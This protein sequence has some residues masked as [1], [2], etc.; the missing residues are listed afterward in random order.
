MKEPS[1]APY[2]VNYVQHEHKGWIAVWFSTSHGKFELLRN[3]LPRAFSGAKYSPQY[4]AWYLGPG[5]TLGQLHALCKR[6]DATAVR[7]DMES[8]Q[9]R[10]GD[11]SDEGIATILYG[12]WKA[13]VDAGREFI[14]VGDS[15][16]DCFRGW[17][18][19]PYTD[20]SEPVDRVHFLRVAREIRNA[21]SASWKPG[22]K[23]RKGTR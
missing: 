9:A 1:S 20:D 13:G 15:N 21:I 23:G 16:M 4:K 22:S 18:K 12:I 8:M 10:A 17:G 3:A 19:L 14:D 7:R 5:A 6:L 2:D 11:M